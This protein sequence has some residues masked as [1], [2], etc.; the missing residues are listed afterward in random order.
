M[1]KIIA[2]FVVVSLTQQTAHAQG[3]VYLSNLGQ[4]PAGNVAVGSDYWLATA[5]GTGTNTGGYSLDSVQ[6]GMADA[7]GN[8]SGF[9]AMIYNAVISTGALPGSSLAALNGSANPSTADVYIYTPVSA[10]TLSPSTTY[11]L[12]LTSGTTV[13]NGACEWSFANSFNNGIGGWGAAYSILNSTDGLHWNLAHSGAAQLAIT[14]E[15]IPEPSV[16]GLLGL[17]GLFLI[18]YRQR[19]LLQLLERHCSA[20]RDQQYSSGRPNSGHRGLQRRFSEFDSTSI[21]NE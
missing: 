10:F 16:L 7:S 11:F 19:F 2:M 5:F 14:A 9:T 13:A 20:V 21:G 6:L 15:A 18:R 17:G 3:I 12:V 1:E 8:P 4:A